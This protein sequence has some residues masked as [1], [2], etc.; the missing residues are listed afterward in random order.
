[1]RQNVFDTLRLSGRTMFD[2]HLSLL[3]VRLLY[4]LHG[5]L[6]L[7]REYEVDVY[8]VDPTRSDSDQIVAGRHYNR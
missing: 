8:L 2:L 3:R 6:Q 5:N 4:C 1:M 7:W